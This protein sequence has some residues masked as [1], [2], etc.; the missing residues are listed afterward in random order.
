M[1]LLNLLDIDV[2]SAASSGLVELLRI[3]R[4]LR[5][6]NNFFKIWKIPN[7]GATGAYRRKDANLLDKELS[8]VEAIALE[9]GHAS[10]IKLKNA[11]A[12]PQSVVASAREHKDDDDDDDDADGDDADGS[13]A[14]WRAPTKVDKQVATTTH[15]VSSTAFKSILLELIT[16]GCT[17]VKSFSEPTRFMVA[18]HSSCAQTESS[19]SRLNSKMRKESPKKSSQQWSA[20]KRRIENPAMNQPNSMITNS[21]SN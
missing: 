18:Y 11:K 14:N 13:G 6:V 7:N 1:I 8:K 21:A 17:N 4:N 2:A 3:W 19:F 15:W 16:R 5:V 10:A 12:A 9:A 20:R